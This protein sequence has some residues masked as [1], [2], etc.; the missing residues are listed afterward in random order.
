MAVAEYRRIAGIASA[1]LFDGTDAMINDI[2]DDYQAGASARAQLPAR[3]TVVT[4]TMT[5]K[6]TSNGNIVIMDGGL[7]STV[8]SCAVLT[9]DTLEGLATKIAAKTY[10]NMTVTALGAVVTMT[11]AAVGNLNG[12]PKVVSVPAGVT[13]TE[14][15]VRGCFLDESA[16]ETLFNTLSCADVQAGTVKIYY[17]SLTPVEIEILETD[18]VAGAIVKMQVGLP[19]THTINTGVAA[20]ATAGTFD[21]QNKTAGENDA[22]IQDIDFGTTGIVSVPVWEQGQDQQGTAIFTFDD[23]NNEN[24]SVYKDDYIA[25][26]FT[27][28]QPLELE[29]QITEVWPKTDFEK[30][31]VAVAT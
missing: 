31:F 23:E 12:N 15:T 8:V 20:S 19:S 16:K 2:K 29:H 30:W 26:L 7:D 17:N 10:A 1:Q 22:V 21:I 28:D 4:L 18:T 25:I 6:A 3:K 27:K 13:Y 9:T 5:H 24:H 14:T 11:A